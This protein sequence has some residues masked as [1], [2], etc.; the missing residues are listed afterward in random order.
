MMIFVPWDI[1]VTYFL[2][3][4][5]YAVL[6]IH[7]HVMRIQDIQPRDELVWGFVTNTQICNLLHPRVSSTSVSFKTGRVSVDITCRRCDRLGFLSSSSV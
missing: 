3:Q 1:I 2:A 6:Q 4:L 5:Q 7:C